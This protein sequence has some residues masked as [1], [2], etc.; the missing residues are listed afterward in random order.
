MTMVVHGVTG[1]LLAQGILWTY[2]RYNGKVAFRHGDLA[3]VWD[4][5]S[6]YYQIKERG[7]T[8]FVARSVTE[9]LENAPEYVWEY[10]ANQI[11]PS[12]EAP[13]FLEAVN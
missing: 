3:I 2:Q 5:N 9:C 13:S 12:W 10:H 4:C 6:G 8:V 7:E 11:V 1:T